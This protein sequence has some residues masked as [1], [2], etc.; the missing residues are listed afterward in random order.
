M[1]IRTRKLIGTIAIVVLVI[2]YAFISML[3][4]IAILPGTHLAL[5]FLYYFIAG[6]FWAL[7]AG[8]IIRWMV[9]E[10]DSA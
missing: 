6:T 5:Q 9:R 4:A 3:V 8:L 2:C 7:P 1:G 10:P